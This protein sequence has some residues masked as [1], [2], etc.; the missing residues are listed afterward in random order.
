MCLI[1]KASH[2]WDASRIWDNGIDEWLTV[3]KLSLNVNKSK[4]MLFNAGNKIV[5]P[6]EIKIDYISLFNRKSVCV[7]LSGSNYG[8]TYKLEVSC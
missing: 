2:L 8:R 3:N 4:Y 6:F 5:Y 1:F 7:Q